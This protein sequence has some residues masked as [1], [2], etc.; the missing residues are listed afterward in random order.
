MKAKNIFSIVFLFLTFLVLC[1]GCGTDVKSKMST[2]YIFVDVT[3][4]TATDNI[5]TESQI[6]EIVDKMGF[7][8]GSN[9]FNLYNGG[10]VKFFSIDDISQTLAKQPE[11]INNENA[12]FFNATP[13]LQRQEIID[14]FTIKLKNSAK[15]FKTNA[16]FGRNKSEIYRNLCSALKELSKQSSDIKNVIIYSDMIE[17]STAFKLINS[18]E[19]SKINS[20]IEKA[21]QICEMPD[22]SEISIY[23]IPPLRSSNQSQIE[24]AKKFWKRLF[25][26]KKAKNL[27]EFNVNLNIK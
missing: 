12:D 20:T 10:E 14:E 9:N 2:T 16:K 24:Q 25:E 11:K 6:D 22:L 15:E 26:I 27:V 8:K 21:S 5:L 19:D 23:V 18:I 17:N 4:S 13:E 1:S 3:D 7:L